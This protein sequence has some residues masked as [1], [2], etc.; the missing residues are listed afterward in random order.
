MWSR[1]ARA[2][3]PRSPRSEQGRGSGP[4]RAFG[5]RPPRSEQGRDSGPARAFSPRSPRSEQGRDS[6][7]TWECSGPSCVRS[8]PRT[9][10]ASVPFRALLGPC[11]DGVSRG[12]LAKPSPLCAPSARSWLHLWTFTGC[13]L[14]STPAS[15][16]KGLVIGRLLVES[17]GRPLLA[18]LVLCG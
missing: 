9:S 10:A 15:E 3:G 17:A 13:G 11:T 4:T 16:A 2:F 18:G 6:G 7:G 1:P 5:P 12:L 14:G 8:P